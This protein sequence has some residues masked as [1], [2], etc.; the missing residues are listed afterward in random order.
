MEMRSARTG[1]LIVGHGERGG[2]NADN[3]GLRKLGDGVGSALDRIGAVVE[4]AVLNGAPLLG[5]AVASLAAAHCREILVYPFFM[6]DGYFTRTRL[7]QSLRAHQPS[8]PWLVLPPLG[9]DAG[10]PASIARKAHCVAQHENL[11]CD[12]VRL[13]IV[14]HGSSQSRASADAADAIAA[15]IRGTRM[16]A[17]VDTAFL[18]EAPFLADEL[19]AIRGHTLVVGLFT[20]DGLHAREDVPAALAGTPH[21]YLGAVGTWPGT[22]GLV[23]HRLGEE[24]ANRRTEG[25]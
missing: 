6:S 20:G 11:P 24:I 7:P 22:V 21:H 4:V 14:G 23:A 8:V 19:A 3:A 17:R 1:V 15:A 10:L 16:F 25:S 5:D 12:D 18:E 13:L 9:L 2:T